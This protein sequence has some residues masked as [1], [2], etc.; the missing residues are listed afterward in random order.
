MV[1]I[2]WPCVGRITGI[3]W[4]EVDSFTCLRALRVLAIFKSEFQPTFLSS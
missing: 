4:L 1:G 3:D 2:L